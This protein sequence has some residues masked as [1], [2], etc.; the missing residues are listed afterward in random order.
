MVPM[1]LSATKGTAI[2]TAATIL[3][4]IQQHGSKVT[5]AELVGAGTGLEKLIYLGALRAYFIRRTDGG[6]KQSSPPPVAGRGINSLA[7]HLQT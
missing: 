3:S 2:N 4:A 7:R 5:I 1:I 6:A